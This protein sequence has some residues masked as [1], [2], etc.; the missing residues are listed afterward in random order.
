MYE[1]ENVSRLNTGTD[2]E[3]LFGGEGIYYEYIFN[4]IKSVLWYLYHSKNKLC[5]L[6]F[7]HVLLQQFRSNNIVVLI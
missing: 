4:M 6:H 5:Q 1:H 7:V 3:Y 2:I